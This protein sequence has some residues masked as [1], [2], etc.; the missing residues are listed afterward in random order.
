MFALA[1]VIAVALHLV[2]QYT[3][4]GRHLYAVGSNPEAARQVGLDDRRVQIAAFVACGALAGLAGFL[5][6]GRFGTINVTAGSGLELAAIAAAVVGGV[7]TLGGSGTVMGAFVGAVLIGLLD[8]SLVRVPQI[9]EFWRDAILGS[10]ILAAVMLDVTVGRAAPCDGARHREAVVG[11]WARRYTWELVLGVI[12]LGT[13]VFN[14]TQS[15]GYLGVDNFVNLFQLHIEKVIVVVTMTFVIIAGEIDLSVASVMAWSA[16]V[17][18]ALHEHDTPLA[19]AI[20]AALAA[21]AVAGLINGLV[22]RQARPAVARRHAGRADRLARRGTRARR[23]PLD[24]RLPAL[25]RP[26]RSGRPR[27]PAAAGPGPLRR[28]VRRRLGRSSTARPPAASSTSSATTPRSPATPASTSTRTRLLLFIASSLVAGLAGILFAAR[29]G[30]VRGDL[31]NGFELE[32]IT[33]VLL[34]GVSIFGGAG[35]MSGVLLAVLI[36]LNL[37][38]GFGLANVGGNAQTGVIGAILIGSVIAQNVIDRFTN[39]ARAP[40]GLPTAGRMA[41]G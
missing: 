37:R 9:S 22:R 4:R 3:R 17:L 11:S 29:V 28:V 30:T 38:N 14:L 19:L 5:Y 15:S 25:V 35:R 24:R 21:A 23:G 31:A 41:S 1:L 18:A 2:L 36:V 33:I 12:L 10:L 26:P 34:G 16:S 27:R 8:L 40:R 39:R 20:V 32:I 13:I 7:S 6:V